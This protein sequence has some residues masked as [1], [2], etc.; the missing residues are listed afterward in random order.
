MTITRNCRTKTKKIT[1]CERKSYAKK[2]GREI[3]AKKKTTEG[4]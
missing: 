4:R 1:K 3:K 2:S